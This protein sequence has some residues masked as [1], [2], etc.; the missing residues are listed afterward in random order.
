[1]A[2][3]DPTVARV[4]DVRARQALVQRLARALDAVAASGLPVVWARKGGVQRAK[5]ELLLADVATLMAAR[6]R[7]RGIGVSGSRDSTID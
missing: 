5:A 3:N 4:R 6:S 2:A 1:M 7:R